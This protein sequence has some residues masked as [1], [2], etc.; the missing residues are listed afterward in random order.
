MSKEKAGDILERMRNTAKREKPIQVGEGDRRRV[1]ELPR[2]PKE[3][4]RVSLDLSKEQHKALKIFAV[5]AET[6]ASAVLRTLL[7]R[8]EEDEELAGAVREALSR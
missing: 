2:D 8:L 5:E 3:R 4:V 7:L 6:D 1:K